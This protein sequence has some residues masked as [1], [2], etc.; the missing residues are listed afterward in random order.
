M[1]KLIELE[2][3]GGERGGCRSDFVVSLQSLLY[4]GPEQRRRNRTRVA[5]IASSTASDVF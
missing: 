3:A 2:M 4:H 1:K 5:P